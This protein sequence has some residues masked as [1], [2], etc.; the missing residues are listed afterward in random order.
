VLLDYCSWTEK[1]GIKVDPL[2]RYGIPVEHLRQLVKDESIETRPGDILFIRSGF[3]KVYEA[4]TEAEEA[5]LEQRKEGTF[6]GVESSLEMASWI[7]ENQFAAVAGDM[8]GFEQS[9]IW[10]SQVQLHQW[11]LAGWGCPIGEMFYLE[12]LARECEKLG[13][14]TFFLSSVPLKVSF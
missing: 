3:T 12:D 14:N 8:P 2:T 5:N 6:I 7:W 1:K 13:R 4:L 9:P 10:N 11:L